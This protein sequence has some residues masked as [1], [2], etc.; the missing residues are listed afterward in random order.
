MTVFGRRSLKS[1]L[2]RRQRLRIAT[3]I[4]SVYY[5]AGSMSVNSIPPREFGEMR[6]MSARTLPFADDS[7][8]NVP[9]ESFAVPKRR[10]LCK[11]KSF[12][13]CAGSEIVVALP[14]P[15]LAIEGTTVKVMLTVS[16]LTLLSRSQLYMSKYKL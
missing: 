3:T 8:V 5:L 9:Y 15:P 4:I 10:V 6:I 7:T 14:E 11:S 1:S 12:P 2:Q 13:L 16:L